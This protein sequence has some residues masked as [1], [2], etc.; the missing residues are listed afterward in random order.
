MRPPPPGGRRVVVDPETGE[1]LEGSAVADED[2]IAEAPAPES[3]ADRPGRWFVV[4]TQSGYEKKVKQNLDP[5][6]R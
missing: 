2:L 4:H 1:I 6:I 3:P 5:R